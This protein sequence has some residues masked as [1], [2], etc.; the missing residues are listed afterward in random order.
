MTTALVYSWATGQRLKPWVLLG[1]AIAVTAL[2]RQ[3]FLLMVPPILAWMVW[4]LA[5]HRDGTGRPVMAP[6]ALVGRIAITVAVLAACILPWTVRNYRAFGQFVLLNTNAGFV[7]FWA[8]HPIHGTQFIPILASGPTNYLTLLPRE[9][10][11][12]NEAQLDRALLVKGFGFVRDD[13]QRYLLLSCSRAKEYF[14][15]WPAPDSGRTSNYV[16]MLSFGLALPLLLAGVALTFTRRGG[17]AHVLSGAT[18]LLLVAT[19]YSVVHLLTWTLV[20]YRLPVDAITMPF[21]GVSLVALLSRLRRLVPALEGPLRA[22][23][24]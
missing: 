7:F 20:R 17:E 22:I 16:R 13:P 9:F 8:N 18:L 4:E 14:R 12:L 5:I 10:E 23:V 2:L 15:F 6:A 3:L 19:L 21:V 1:G 24:N 11:A